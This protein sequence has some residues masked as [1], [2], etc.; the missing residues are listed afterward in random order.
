MNNLFLST[1]TDKIYIALFNEDTIINK[2]IHQG[3]NDHTQNLYPLL[4]SMDIDFD[5]INK[6]YV[7]NGPGSFTGIRLGLVFTKLLAQK[8]DIKLYPVNLIN[9]LESMYNQPIAIDAR[10]GNYYLLKDNEVT[11][12]KEITDCYLIDPEINLDLLINNR[13]LETINPVNY[14]DIGAIYV[15]N[16][17]A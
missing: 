8:N 10:G 12:S 16:P 6:I 4:E 7:V 1:A 14:L 11:I 9:L 13:Y 17:I 5:S 3:N 15:K 2:V